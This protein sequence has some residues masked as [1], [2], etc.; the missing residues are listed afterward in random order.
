MEN[1]HICKALESLIEVI[2]ESTFK[3]VTVRIAKSCDFIKIFGMS[4]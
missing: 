2:S 1:V 3:D 4:V